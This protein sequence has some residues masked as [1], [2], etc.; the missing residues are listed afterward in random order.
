MTDNAKISEPDKMFGTISTNCKTNYHA[1]CQAHGCMCI[2]H[3]RSSLNS[4]PIQSAPAPQYERC[5]CGH[6]QSEHRSVNGFGEGGGVYNCGVEEND[7][8]C[9]CED[10]EQAAPQDDKESAVSVER[11]GKYAFTPPSGA[12]D[13]WSINDMEK[14]YSVVSVQSSFPGAEN[15]VRFA[16]ESIESSPA[17]VKEEEQGEFT[18]E[19]KNIAD[20]YGTGQETG[21]ADGYGDAL[22]GNKPLYPP[23]PA[24]KLP[25]NPIEPGQAATPANGVHEMDA[26]LFTLGTEQP[27]IIASRGEPAGADF[28][29]LEARGSID[30]WNG[31]S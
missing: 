9:P 19:D 15:I 4:E 25:I 26:R 13:W 24:D 2:C 3:S 5:I 10:F 18:E 31:Q 29:S 22:A 8:Q 27:T 6:S 28:I 21:Y 11:K 20:A 30:P 16:W 17:P 14:M 12:Y 7:V 23:T 1:D